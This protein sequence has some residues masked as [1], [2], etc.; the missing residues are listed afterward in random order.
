MSEL[1]SDPGAS[2]AGSPEPSRRLQR[3]LRIHAAG[4]GVLRHAEFDYH[5]AVLLGS[6]RREGRGKQTLSRGIDRAF[7][8]LT[9]AVAALQGSHVAVRSLAEVEHISL[10]AVCATNKA[11]EYALREYADYLAAQSHDQVWKV[12]KRGPLRGRGR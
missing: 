9:K 11:F 10:E 5:G 2:P 3:L 8:T 4:V 1:Q 12:A 7:A 6:L